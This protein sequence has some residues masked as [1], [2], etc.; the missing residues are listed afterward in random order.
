MNNQTG[1]VII[2]NG[3][4]SINTP[5]ALGFG[6]INLAG[7]GLSEP[8]TGQFT[9]TNSIVVTGTNSSIQVN[10]PGGQQLTIT[11]PL[12]GLGGTLTLENITT[13]NAATASA[14][15]TATNINFGLPV[16]L[17][18][19]TGT[20]FLGEFNT[21][22][23]HSWSGI[24]TDAGG[25][26][27][28]GSGGTTLLSNTNTYSGETKLSGGKIGLGSSTVESTP[29]T[30]DAG[31]V[32]TGQFTIDTGTAAISIYAA[33]GSQIVA[34]PINYDNTNT[35]VPF[36]INGANNLNLSG[37]FD[38]SGTNRVIEVDNSVVGRHHRR[39]Q[40]LWFHQ[41]RR[42]QPVSRRDQ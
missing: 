38:L 12:V 28:N 26:W 22:G 19:G 32:G 35:S 25:I 3:V 7:G 15:F 31:P 2:S 24:I 6:L 42:G 34:N 16:D 10:S 23:T 4:V 41:N 8:G 37:L 27:R 39:R 18:N 14:E 1:G 5:A 20:I 17:N 13:K 29:P 40:C 30:I 21:S 11:A 33:G 9:I 36:I